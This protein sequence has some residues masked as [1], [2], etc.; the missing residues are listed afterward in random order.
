M[1]FY[2]GLI[3]TV[4]GNSSRRYLWDWTDD[5]HEGDSI[6][7]HTVTADTGITVDSSSIETWVN[8]AG[9]TRTGVEVRISAND[10]VATDQY[11]VTVQIE[12]AGGDIDDATVIFEIQDR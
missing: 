10:L 7:D 8:D 9:E 11:S 1:D 5:L 3:T 2:V 6:S 12:T 4:D